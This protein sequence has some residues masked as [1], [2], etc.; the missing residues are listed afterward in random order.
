M[1]LV[2]LG[3]VISVQPVHAGGDREAYV[4]TRN[5]SVEELAKIVYEAA[6]KD[7]SNAALV[8][9]DALRSRDTWSVSELK[10]VTDAL[11]LAVPEMATGDLLSL[12][13][14]AEI[15]QNVIDETMKLV[16]R[17]YSA[18]VDHVIEALPPDIPSYPIVPTPPPVSGVR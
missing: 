11:L 18:T 6:K 2:C 8:F 5:L 3:A 4:T 9:M 7:S 15:P 16:T 12:F 17:D 10:F 14:N 13:G 1:L